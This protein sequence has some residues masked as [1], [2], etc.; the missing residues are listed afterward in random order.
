MKHPIL[1]NLALILAVSASAPAAVLVVSPDEYPT[2]QAA[3]DDANVGDTV[4]L[5]PRTYTGPGNRDIDFRGKAI[6]VRSVAPDSPQIVAATVID[7]NGSH[8]GFY[9]HSYEG[10]ASVLEGLTIT[11]GYAEQG[12]AI[13]CYS[14]NPTIT[15]CS[16]TANT[17]I[18]GG[19]LYCR[20]SSPVVTNCTFSQNLADMG[21]GLYCKWGGP[22]TIANC[23]FS[24]NEADSGGG[25]YY[26]E[27]G[28]TI[29]DC[30]FSGNSAACSGGGVCC[31]GYSRALIRNCT[32]AWNSVHGTSC[33]GGGGGMSNRGNGCSPSVI[34]CVFTGNYAPHG[35]GMYNEF[36]ASPKLTECSFA[37]NSAT[38]GG[39]A[40]HNRMSSA[41]L[42]HCTLSKNSASQGGAMCNLYGVTVVLA[43]CTL[44]G[45]LAH[46]GDGGGIYAEYGL[47]LT[48]C[49]FSANSAENGGGI[50]SYD[51]TLSNC[52]FTGNHAQHVGGGVFSYHGSL[53]NCV[54]WA[55]T[56]MT[57]T[58][59][60]AQ[61]GGDVS[62]VAV[63]FSCIQDDDPNDEY[64]PFGGP[65]KGNIDD[66]PVFVRSADDGGDGWGDDPWTLD[67]DEGANDDFGDV[68]LTLTSPCIN[69]GDP[70]H[71]A[72][73]NHVDMDSQPRVIG[74]RIDMGADEYSP[75]ILVTKPEGGEVWVS[76][77]RHE[78]R[79]E[80]YGAGGTVDILLSTNNGADWTT[81]EDNL[82][83]TGSYL[84]HLPEEADSNQC[85]VSVV[86]GSPNPY[87]ICIESGIFTIHPDTPGPVVPSKWKSLG[88]DFDRAGLSDN[89]GPELG[90]IKWRFQTEEPVH[91]SVTIGAYDRLHIACDDGKLYT[92]DAN[93]AP[94]WSY[95]ANSA[96]LSAP[97]VGPDGTVYVGGENGKVYAIDIGGSLR[98]T[99]TAGEF[100]YSSPAVSADGNNIYV[101]SGD[102]VLH[103]LGRDG[104]VLW[105]FQTRP[106]GLVT[107]PIFASPA[108]GADGTVYACGFH[109]PNLYALDPNNGSLKWACSFEHVIGPYYPD[110][111]VFGL[112]FA[113]PVVAPDGTIYQT[114]LYEPN[115]FAIEPNTGNILWSL[116]LMDE[117][118]S[119]H[120]RSTDSVDGWSEPALGPDGT[121][122][123]S[124]NDPH[125]RA[126][127]PNGSLKWINRLGMYEGFTLTVGS[128]GL[129]YAAGYDG[130]LCVVDPNGAELSRLKTDDWLIFPVIGQDNTL[131]VSDGNNT[132]LAIGGD[133]C[134]ERPTALHRPE[135][136]DGSHATNFADLALL[137]ADWLACND[138]FPPCEALA[139]DGTYFGGD[140]NRNLYV[141]F[142][143]F[144]ALANR[145][146]SEE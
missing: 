131:I 126:V 88:G 18:W 86:P 9:F 138:P 6:T 139:W 3:I 65:A 2:I 127:D 72:A 114:L 117:L 94:L 52:T 130:Y 102:G 89:Y 82:A 95:D 124:L 103:A 24:A 83:D 76:G 55:N 100:M 23:T 33:Y 110:Y 92:L 63:T 132:I 136:L 109:D 67:V 125:L 104:S 123:V 81:I 119:Y 73:W 142:G 44:T 108:V 14:S 68:H 45:N 37:D 137:A 47:I 42:Q 78:I 98:W 144:A 111:Y 53:I 38:F 17:A 51:P 20:R 28:G 141:D 75:I 16:F 50:S 57:G 59:E 27:S 15:N 77:S 97:T 8:R 133:D 84:W 35:G 70:G 74:G 115:L 49:L 128:D 106:I 54:L 61:I 145:W 1:L 113:S 146:L 69:A 140:I 85:V 43:N 120:P 90:C 96:L 7:C 134:D 80:S 46:H 58:G 60:S 101:G 93:G 112:P 31:V 12:G 48:N 56:D 64:V 143:D 87:V 40:I 107:G 91:T 21:G 41:T 71:T 26:D 66:N 11:N 36:G 121:I 22:T 129:I 118:P 32:F 34:Q 5:T 39:G 19:G 105:T 79:W 30:T 135:D 116:Q 99:H 4:V 10:P 25:I 62:Y 29:T 122:Y 13:Y